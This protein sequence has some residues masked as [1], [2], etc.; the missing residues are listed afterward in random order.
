MG[1]EKILLHIPLNDD[2][3]S[4][5]DTD[6][7][8]SSVSNMPLIKSNVYNVWYF[9]L[10]LYKFV[11]GLHYINNTPILMRVKSYGESRNLLPERVSYLMQ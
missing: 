10:Y 1:V 8:F 4:L 6:I 2:D 9:T 7:T 3:V 11:A 5:F